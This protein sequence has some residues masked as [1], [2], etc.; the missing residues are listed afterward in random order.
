M[1]IQILATYHLINFFGYQISA[2][3]SAILSIGL[4]SGA[5]ISQIILSGINSVNKGQIEAAKALGFSQFQTTRFIVLPQ[6]IRNILPALGNEFVTL[7]KDSSLAS[8]I[9]VYELS[10]QGSIIISQ[11]FDAPTIY[12][13]IGLIY[14]IMTSTISIAISFL[15]GKLKYNVEN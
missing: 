9:G 10:K 6:A 13:V 14:L 7:I 2:L 12:I 5:Y 8:T 4:N 1:L 15:G 11:T 3:N